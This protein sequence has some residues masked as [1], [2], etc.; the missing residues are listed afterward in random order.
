MTIKNL[1]APEGDKDER[2]DRHSAD[3]KSTV[4]APAKKDGHGGGF[5]WGGPQNFDD[6]EFKPHAADVGAAKLN[7]SAGDAAQG[8]ADRESFVFKKD[9]FPALSNSLD[10]ASSPAKKANEKNWGRNVALDSDLAL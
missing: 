5:T 7:Q 2:K 4:N 6:A 10:G 1:K 3:V 8:N 9:E